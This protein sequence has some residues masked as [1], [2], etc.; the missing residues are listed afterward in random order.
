[1]SRLTVLIS[2]AALL[3]SAVPLRA[4]ITQKYSL[5]YMR[6]YNS[7]AAKV[8]KGNFGAS[9]EMEFHL[10]GVPDF[11]SWGAGLDL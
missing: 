7:D 5:N 8:S 2:I 4:D 6:P 11:I 9:W 1:M 3:L 10:E